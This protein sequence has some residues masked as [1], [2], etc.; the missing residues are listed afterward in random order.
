MHFSVKF[1]SFLC[2]WGV[3]GWLQEVS[4]CV[5]GVPGGQGK[6]RAPEEWLE[7]SGGG[8]FL[9]MPFPVKSVVASCAALQQQAGEEKEEE[10]EEQEEEDEQGG[11]LK[12]SRNVQNRIVKM[13][14][15]FPW[16]AGIWMLQVW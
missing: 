7:S 12:Q 8:V 13:I 11:A 16:M 10:E 5:P 14:R 2:S 3:F 15:C 9:F 1:G 6:P 4:I